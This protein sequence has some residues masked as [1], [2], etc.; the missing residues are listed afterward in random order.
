[1]AAAGSGATT[2]APISI[3]TFLAELHEA[4]PIKRSNALNEFLAAISAGDS[5]GIKYR[6]EKCAPHATRIKDAL[7]T[8][9]EDAN[10]EVKNKSALILINL[11]ES[12]TI[13]LA[14]A[15]KKLLSL[16]LNHIFNDELSSKDT[17][18]QGCALSALTQLLEFDK[19]FRSELNELPLIATLIEILTP[20]ALGS[21]IQI[22]ALIALDALL[23]EGKAKDFLTITTTGA[24]IIPN[25]IATLEKAITVKNIEMQINITGIISALIE[26]NIAHKQAFTNKNIVPLLIEMLKKS[27][28]KKIIHNG[29]TALKYLIKNNPR[30]PELFTD[31]KIDMIKEI[32]PT[33]GAKLGASKVFDDLIKLLAEIPSMTRDADSRIYSTATA[34]AK[35]LSLTK[36]TGAALV[37]E[38]IEG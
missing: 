1:M 8:H 23:P 32:L 38:D 19:D 25:I 37:L 13:S 17:E 2:F 10:L 24:T 18:R 31:L 4:A 29:L 5:Q 28:D 34:M 26:K 27:T 35:T 3:E 15:E 6:T 33:I 22:Q 14:P 30:A 36:I 9:L 11:L 16:I 12:T 21:A 20:D 7:I